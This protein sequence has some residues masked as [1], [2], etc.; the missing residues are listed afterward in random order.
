MLSQFVAISVTTGIK[1]I[2]TGNTQPAAP[3]R[4]AP[5]PIIAPEIMLFTADS[6]ETLSYSPEKMLLIFSNSSAT[7][8]E[9]AV[10]PA[11]FFKDFKFSVKFLDNFQAKIPAPIAATMG[12]IDSMVFFRLLACSFNPSKK[13]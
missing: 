10:N 4:I 13:L 6:N 8:I 12:K 11:S 2:A 1:A 5:T 9:I 7:P 3:S